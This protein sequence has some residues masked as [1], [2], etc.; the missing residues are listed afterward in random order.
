MHKNNEIHEMTLGVHEMT[1][2]VHEMKKGLIT[3]SHR[4]HN[5]ES[6]ARLKVVNLLGNFFAVEAVV[7]FDLAVEDRKSLF[8]A[9][10]M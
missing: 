6:C 5:G 2:G 3:K 9:V 8:A 10:N 7:D 1:L 4:H